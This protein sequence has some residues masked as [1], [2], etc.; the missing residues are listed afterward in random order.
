VTYAGPELSLIIGGFRRTCPAGP[1]KR[2]LSWWI[3]GDLLDLVGNGER[4]LLQI[5]MGLRQSI[6]IIDLRG[7]MVCEK[8]SGVDD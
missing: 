8:I 4:G 5:F 7:D 1:L 3:R 6:I 2:A